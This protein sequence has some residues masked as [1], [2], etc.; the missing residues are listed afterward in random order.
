M[1][2]YETVEKDQDGLKLIKL[3]RK[4]YFEKDGTKQAIL[5]IVEAYKRRHV[6]QRIHA[7]I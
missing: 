2:G 5:E 4:A 3:L 7:G 6:N 1:D